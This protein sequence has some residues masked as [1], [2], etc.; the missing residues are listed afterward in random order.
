MALECR[1]DQYY[2][3]E[4]YRDSYFRQDGTLV[5]ASSIEEHCRSYQFSSP[6]KIKFSS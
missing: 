1:P 2:V 3:S 4:H 5:K 6:L